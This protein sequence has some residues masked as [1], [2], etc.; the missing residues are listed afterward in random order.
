MKRECHEGVSGLAGRAAS[1]VRRFHAHQGGQAIY[2]VVMYMFLLLGLLVLVINSGE[3]VNHKIEMQGAADSAAMTGAA[4]Y[5]RGLNVV[6]MCDVGEVQ[7]LSTIVLCD[8]LE[9]V[10]PAAKETIDKLHGNLE[11]FDLRL[12]DPNASSPD[13]NIFLVAGKADSEK[14]VVYQF[15]DIVQTIKR[16]PGGWGKYLNYNGGVLWDCMKLL[17][18]F[19]HVM[20][21][22][23]PRAACR[24]AAD[25]AKKNHADFGFMTPFWPELPIEIGQ[26]QDFKDPMRLGTLPARLLGRPGY[27][28]SRDLRIGG[29]RWGVMNYVCY[30]STYLDDRSRLLSLRGPRGPWSYWREPFVESRPMGLLDL[31]GFGDLF[32]AVSSMKFEMLFGGAEDKASLR[33]WEYDYDK[34]R[35][36]SRNEIRRTWWEDVG[37]DARY[38]ADEERKPFP[39]PES[40]AWPA[41]KWGVSKDQ[42]YPRTRTYPNPGHWPPDPRVNPWPTDMGN[43]T[44]ATQGYEGVDPRRNVWYR[45]QRQRTPLYPQLGIFAPHPPMHPDGS[46][47]EYTEAEKQ[48]YWHI[49]MR[50]FN[51]AEL[52]PDTTLHRDYMPA[53][54]EDPD[55]APVF[56]TD[57]GVNLVEN[58]EGPSGRFTFNGYAYR[59]A[60]ATNWVQRFINPNPTEAVVCYAQTRV[61]NPVGWDLFTQNW[62]AK[63]MRAQ[64][65]YSENDDRWGVMRS[66]LNKGIPSQAAQTVDGLDKKHV[67]PVLDTVSAHTP[68][69][70]QEI[71]H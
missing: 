17:D 9:T 22:D 39:P 7:L 4:W 33:N 32:N 70:V 20:V 2:I 49:T 71:T 51:G 50:R 29:F 6:S 43:Y 21:L 1:A 68:A 53:L 23:T 27:P 3:K 25:V 40:G 28:T 47:W 59:A 42:I 19:S 38:V 69:F 55:I 34:A 31:S 8:T 5:A 61:Y 65:S 54:G 14:Q 24:E 66:E 60:K 35:S 45:V 63:L 62:K 56:F 44:R 30:G 64:F 46:K 67:K 52:E 13:G 36:K 11:I 12:T 26:F 10:T 57:Q 18:G 48:T 37:F 15:D 41:K 58:I 16:S